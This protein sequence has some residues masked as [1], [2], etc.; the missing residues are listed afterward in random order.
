MCRPTPSRSSW[1]SVADVGDATTNGPSTGHSGGTAADLH[2][3]PYS[4]AAVQQRTPAPLFDEAIKRAVLKSVKSAPPGSTDFASF[5]HILDPSPQQLDHAPRLSDAAARRKRRLGVKYLR[6][7]AQTRLVQV[8]GKAIEKCAA[9]LAT[10]AT[11]ATTEGGDVRADEPA[12]HRALVIRAVAFPRAAL[13]PSTVRRGRS[14]RGS[15]GHAESA[16]VRQSQIRSA[17][18]ARPQ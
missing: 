16:S 5:P 2:C 13:I 3:L 8:C 15:A 9:T 7:R 6:D 18:P 17:A 4:S 10:Y 1:E 14:A 11:V 12:P